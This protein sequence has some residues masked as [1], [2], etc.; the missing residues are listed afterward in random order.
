MIKELKGI[1]S[2]AF[3]G[4]L[5]AMFIFGSEITINFNVERA[6]KNVWDKVK[7]GIQTVA[8]IK[9]LAQY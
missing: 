5:I 9:Q 6:K 8:E 4:F 1:I 3:M 2:L 7:S